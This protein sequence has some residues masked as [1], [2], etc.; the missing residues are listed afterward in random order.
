MQHSITR[1]S[2]NLQLPFTLRHARCVTVG[3]THLLQGVHG[4][5]EDGLP[6]RPHKHDENDM[7]HQQVYDC[8]QKQERR[9]PSSIFSG[10]RTLHWTRMMLVI[11]FHLFHWKIGRVLKSACGNYYLLLCQTLGRCK[12]KWRRNQAQW[13]SCINSALSQSWLQYAA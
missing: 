10:A 13:T 6:V 4:L 1:G 11:Q 5:G 7:V 12:S 3:H 9:I 2:A 8:K